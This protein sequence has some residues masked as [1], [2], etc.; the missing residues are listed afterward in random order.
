MTKQEVKL[1]KERDTKRKVRY[2]DD[3]TFGPLY[4]PKEWFGVDIPDEITIEVV[5]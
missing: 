1:Q 4:V 2:N 3:G 5:W